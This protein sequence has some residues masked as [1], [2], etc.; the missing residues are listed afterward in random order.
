MSFKALKV[1]FTVADFKVAVNLPAVAFDKA[2]A[3]AAEICPLVISTL[4]VFLIPK[5]DLIALSSGAAPSNLTIVAQFGSDNF[6]FK[7]S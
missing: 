4:T 3:S 6:L 7:I 5:A 1:A 2:F